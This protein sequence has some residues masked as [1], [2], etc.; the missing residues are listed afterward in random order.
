MSATS[1]RN[2]LQKNG[3]ISRKERLDRNGKIT[4]G[5]SWIKS[6]ADPGQVRHDGPWNRH[7]SRDCPA[8]QGFPN[9]VNPANAGIQPKFLL[10]L[11]KETRTIMRV[12]VGWMLD[13]DSMRRL[14]SR[15]V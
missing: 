12:K 2:G 7:A 1:N 10:S 14:V 15:E 6:G 9:T 4:A 13:Q 11:F 8:R 5:C 3:D